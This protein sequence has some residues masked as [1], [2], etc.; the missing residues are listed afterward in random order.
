MCICF[1][2]LNSLTCN[3]QEA[4]EIRFRMVS[5]DPS[6]EIDKKFIFNAPRSASLTKVTPFLGRW[7]AK[8]GYEVKKVP[9]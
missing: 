5:L 4:S 7:L 6:V 8:A 1:P 3:L 2:V 9:F